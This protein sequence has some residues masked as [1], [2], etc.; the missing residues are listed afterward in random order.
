MQTVY[1]IKYSSPMVVS[2]PTTREMALLPPLLVS[3]C[4]AKLAW[5]SA[6]FSVNVLFVVHVVPLEL[7]AK[8]LHT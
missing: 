1:T 6:P 2:T 3:D 7:S 5:H 4:S 8:A